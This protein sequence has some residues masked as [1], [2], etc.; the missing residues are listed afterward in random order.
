MAV[1]L[2]VTDVA[3]GRIVL[4]D[5]VDGEIQAGRAFSVGGIQSTESSADP[6]ADVQRVVAARISEKIVTFHF[7]MK[8]IQAQTDGTLIINYGNV[9]LAPSGPRQTDCTLSE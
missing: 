3:T 1:D 8:V 4:A 5:S 9:F 6:F 2:R 7:P